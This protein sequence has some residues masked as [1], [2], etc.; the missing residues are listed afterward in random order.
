MAG[1]TAY[2]EEN[3]GPVLLAVMWT[4]TGL[5]MVMVLARLFIRTKIIHAVGLDD[6]LIGFSMILGLANVITA[7]VAVH[8][9]F[10]QHSSTIGPAATEKA[11]L[12][13]DIGWIFG[14]LSFAFPKLG[15]AALLHRILI[16]G[17]RMKCA[18]WGLTGL[19]M[20]VAVVN[21]LLFFTSCDPPRALWMT[22]AGATCRSSNVIIGFATFN[23]ALSAFTDLSL[24]IYPSVILWKLQMSLR[25]KLALSAAL[26][27]G[28]ISACAA[29]IKTTHLNALANVTDATYAGWSLVLWTN[30]EADLVVLAS[31]IPTLQPLLEFLLGKRSYGTP[32]SYPTYEGGGTGPS[33]RTGGRSTQPVSFPSRMDSQEEMI[34][35]AKNRT[36]WEIHRTDQVVVEYEMGEQNRNQNQNARGRIVGGCRGR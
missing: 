1:T 36:M 3:K 19:V 14:I 23:G 8:H 26:G 13:I 22:V 6:W 31:C 24:A 7:T 27:L 25:K 34:P 11:N 2:D 5:A 33:K 29:I 17:I 28:A 32:R 30:I 35:D 9:G 12:T 20:A 21:I 4:L 15:V 18:L 10:G 16:P